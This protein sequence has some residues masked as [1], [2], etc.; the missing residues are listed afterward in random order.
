MLPGPHTVGFY[1]AEWGASSKGGDWGG[2]EVHEGRFFLGGACLHRQELV[3]PRLP[4][5]PLALPLS[6]QLS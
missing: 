6:I 4:S 5:R 1:G 3:N 2:M